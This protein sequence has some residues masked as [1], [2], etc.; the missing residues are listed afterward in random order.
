MSPIGPHPETPMPSLVLFALS[1]QLATAS[2]PRPDDEVRW[3]PFV[4]RAHDGSELE[5]RLGRLRVPERHADPNGPTIE[6]AFVVYETENPDPGPPFVYL[7]GGPGGPGIDACAAE[8]TD[9]RT[10]LLERADVIGI[11][12]RGTGRSVPNLAD[13]PAFTWELPLDAPAGRDDVARAYREAVARCVEH[14]SERGVDLAA[15]TTVESADDVDRVRA[16]LGYERIVP[17]GTS[18]GSHLGLAY[19]RR[20]ADHAARAVLS[21]VEGPDATWKLPSQVQRRLEQVDEL[22]RADPVWSRELPSFVD[23]VRALLERLADEPARVPFPDED[24]QPIEL[25]IGAHDVRTALAGALGYARTTADL[26]FVVHLMEQG[27]FRHLAKAALRNRRGEVGSAMPLAMDCASGATRARRERIERERVDPRNL[28]AD[29]IAAPFYPETCEPCGLDL[30]E[31]FRAPFA[32]DV[33]VLFVSG[34]LDA[35]TPP[36]NVD[37]LAAGFS[38]SAHV[39]V[40]GTGHDARELESE[41]FL[42]LLDA[43]LS[44]RPVEDARIELPPLELRPPL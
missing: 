36:E 41:A 19:L 30:G 43:F 34:D 6:I 1:F 4:G 44:G 39:V 38:R 14:W 27:E 18:Y 15:Y 8:A 32:C 23:A 20:H 22:V 21:K 24:G 26:P 7:V 29:A 31:E 3:E 42:E 2:P 37:A 5:G 28:L 40:A 13:A 9:P 25:V 33:P 17:W 35:R 11:D 16:A 12:Q 10:R